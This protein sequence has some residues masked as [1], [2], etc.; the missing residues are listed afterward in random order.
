MAGRPRI[1]VP[2]DV[3]INGRHVGQLRR[4]ASGAID[5]Q[6]EADWL[7]WEN[8]FPVSLSL[9]LREDRYIGA[10]V[11]AVFDNLLPDN[12]D[13]R[14]RLAARTRAA[15]TDAFSLLTAVGRDC[16]GAL[17]FLPAGGDP[18]PSGKVEGRPL[19]D[20]EIAAILRDL[21]QFPLGLTAE[22]EFRISL[23]GAQEKTA[24]LWWNN[25]WN[26]PHGA[27]PTTHILKPE[28][29]QL[30]NGIDLSESVENEFLCLRLAAAVGLP[31]PNAFIAT[32]G[33][34]RTLVVE[35]FDRR[36][37]NDGRLLRLPQEDM[38]QA[39][40]VPPTMKYESEGGPGM[41]PAL[42]LLKASDEPANDQRIFL[43][44]QIFF[45]L[46]GATDGHA[47]NFSLFLLPGG[48][49]RLAPLYDI[50]STQPNV[51][52]GQIRHNQFKLAMA[53]GENRH[54]RVN[55]IQPRH[56]SQTAR[57]AGMPTA[58]ADELLAEMA[59]A[60]PRALD[61]VARALPPGFPATLVD[62]IAQGAR[63]RLR[64][65]IA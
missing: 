41:V 33:D 40:S 15:G 58:V 51:D 39:L 5:F 8:A 2:L 21:G 36:W 18:G 65:I 30:A 42:D 64:T 34:K 47:K 16:I 55:T 10:P 26:I 45:W 62:R 11:I 37:T 44:A 63:R 13:V 43:K 28:I 53:V 24:L 56:F 1:R 7:A 48:R 59:G 32:F 31:V 50:M 61:E 3:F 12:E 49:F 27:A 57:S 46:I 54:Y 52:A 6:Y 60:T 35:R 9:P 23:T 19:T 17:Q 38:C 14:R 25:Q 29:G 4:E 20:P 22:S